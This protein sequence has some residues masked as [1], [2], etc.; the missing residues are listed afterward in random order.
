MSPNVMEGNERR[1][2]ERCNVL[3]MSFL[4]APHCLSFSLISVSL[5][6]GQPIS[7][8]LF[9]SL[10][11]MSI[12]NL[13][14]FLAIFT[15][16]KNLKKQPQLS[17]SGQF[18]LPLSEMTL[19]YLY[20]LLRSTSCHQASFSLFPE[21]KRK[22]YHL[23]V[24]LPTH[25]HLYSTFLSAASEWTDPSLILRQLPCAPDPTTPVLCSC[26]R[27]LLLQLSLFPL[28]H[29]FSLY[30]ELFLSTANP[31]KIASILKTENKSLFEIT[32]PP[33]TSL[34]CSFKQSKFL[35]VVPTHCLHLTFFLPLLVTITVVWVELCPLKI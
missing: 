33:T 4:H 7:V 34:L 26:P 3:L 15:F 31:G 9:S 1:E 22:T 2:G 30:T 14:S 5:S 32:L 11:L 24:P 12:L 10:S 13:Y 23:L 16:Q 18:S 20:P 19:S 25:L 35:V 6:S 17:S 8:S 21:T 27:P 28:H 29:N